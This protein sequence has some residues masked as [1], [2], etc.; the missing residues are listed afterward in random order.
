MRRIG[1][2]DVVL[3][4]IAVLRIVTVDVAAGGQGV[5]PLWW[6]GLRVARGGYMRV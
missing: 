3:V 5:V 1:E 2:V 6:G 4:R